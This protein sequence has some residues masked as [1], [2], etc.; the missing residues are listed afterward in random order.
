MIDWTVSKR[1]LFDSVVWLP[2]LLVAVM[3]WLVLR[4]YGV[5]GPVQLLA[6]LHEGI[7][8]GTALSE[9]NPVAWVTYTANGVLNDFRTSILSLLS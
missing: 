3:T 1:G 2:L 6:Q 4:D 5:P 7:V 8:N 9:L